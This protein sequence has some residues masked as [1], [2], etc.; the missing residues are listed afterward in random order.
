MLAAAGFS[1]VMTADP[2]TGAE[3]RS[4]ALQQTDSALH[5]LYSAAPPKTAEF[6]AGRIIAT[7]SKGWTPEELESRIAEYK[8]QFPKSANNVILRPLKVK[9]Q[10][11]LISKAK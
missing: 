5:L 2:A 4:K 10:S 11:F 1:N 3:D 8:K 7:E 9:T 6:G